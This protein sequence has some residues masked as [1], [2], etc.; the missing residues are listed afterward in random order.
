MVNSILVK[1]STVKFLTVHTFLIIK[2][3]IFQIKILNEINFFLG[4]V[5]ILI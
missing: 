1:I 5:Q 4:I 2:K 3:Q